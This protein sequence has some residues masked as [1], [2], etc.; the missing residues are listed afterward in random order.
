MGDD[1]LY[2][3][4]ILKDG[5]KQQTIELK[6]D[7]EG[8][9]VATI[10]R[11]LSNPDSEKAVLYI[12]GFNDYFFQREMGHRFNDHG[13]NFYALD[14]R[15]Y[16]RSHLSHQKFND[17]RNLKDYYEEITSVLNIIHSENNKETILFGHSTGG[18][19]LTLYAKDHAGSKLF[20]GLILN[21]PFF[22]FNKSWFVRKFIPL[23]AYIGRIFP[24]LKIPGGFAK[25]YGE[26]LHKS[27]SGEWEYDLAWKPNIAP[28]VNLGWIRAIH[29]AQ[30]E[31]RRIFKIKQPVLVLHSSLSAT[32]VKDK[33]QIQTRDAILNVKDIEQIARNIKGD[34]ETVAI[35]GGLHDLVLSQKPVREKVY[36]TIFDWLK[37]NNL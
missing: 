12:H 6:D 29:K 23:A 1:V 11:R 7:Y 10:I 27:Y 33:Q 17:I 37:K 35:E 31:L 21:S 9:A 15:K 8:R 32:D 25:E 20:D 4:D 5:F 13:Y 14:L 24:K 16:G 19:I 30:V 18:L 26:N 3:E 2:F 36:N 22:E 34:V 28:K